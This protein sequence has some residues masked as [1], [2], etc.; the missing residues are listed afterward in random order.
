[1]TRVMSLQF[2]HHHR[3]IEASSTRQHQISRAMFIV[4]NEDFE[5]GTTINTIIDGRPQEQC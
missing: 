4:T 1:M 5:R 3:S 2:E